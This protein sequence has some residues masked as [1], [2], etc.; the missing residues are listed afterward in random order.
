MSIY[1]MIFAALT[2]LCLAT[3][4]IYGSPLVV[5]ILAVVIAGVSVAADTCRALSL[6]IDTGK[7][8]FVGLGGNNLKTVSDVTK[9]AALH[10]RA[11]DFK[12]SELVQCKGK[13]K[14]SRSVWGVCLQ[15]LLCCCSQEG[16]LLRF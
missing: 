10:F 11:L 14:R 9:A 4:C 12:S 5:F 2:I 15:D 6:L 3:E 7:V 16:V 1:E 8:G 13:D